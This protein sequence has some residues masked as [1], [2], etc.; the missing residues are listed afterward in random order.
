MAAHPSLDG[1][2]VEAVEIIVN[3]LAFSDICSL[4]LTGHE[5]NAKSSQGIFKSHFR[6]KKIVM[7][8]RE[9]Q[10]AVYMTQ[11]REVGGLLE[12][13]TLVGLQTCRT[14]EDDDIDA[15]YILGRPRTT[16][17][18]R[19]SN[20][21]AGRTRNTQAGLL[22]SRKQEVDEN[23]AAKLL[24]QAMKNLRL[25]LTGGSLLSL[26]LMVDDLSGGKGYKYWSFKGAAIPSARPRIWE[27]AAQLFQTTAHALGVSELPIES[28]DIF[29]GVICCS[30]ACDRIAT[31]LERVNL[32]VSLRGLKHLSISLSQH[33][34]H[35][36]ESEEMQALATGERHTKAICQL[37]QLCP[38][39]EDLQLHW[40][41]LW[42]SN[43]TA[44]VAEEVNFLNRVAQSCRFP[45]LKRWSLK[46]VSTS[47]STL[48]TF[49]RQTQLD[50]V[51]MEEIHLQSGKF[52]PVFD[53]L[54]EHMQLQHVHLDNLWEED[55]I[56]FEA[57]GEPDFPGSEPSG[58]NAITRTGADARKH[59]KGQFIGGYPLDSAPFSNWCARREKRYGRL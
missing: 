2:P 23:D 57:P 22:T 31:C 55:L 12:H 15:V 25:S 38:V 59:I 30:L 28:F 10:T 6:S 44:A 21:H 11:R 51:E 3:L 27:A 35:E 20:A 45:S 17:A 54:V 48:L 13:L 26:S 52:R 1:I 41:S 58:P 18:E 33:V 53:Y 8:E 56:Y 50:R 42:D 24:G 9:L 7:T 29:G 43:H 47:E 32:S 14:Q 19:I 37:L 49:L 46:G 36:P 4:R 39:L 40:Y 34:Q 5:L 16:L